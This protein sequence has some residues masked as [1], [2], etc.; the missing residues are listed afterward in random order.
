MVENGYRCIAF[1]TLGY[2]ESSSPVDLASY[3]IKSVCSQ[4]F[5]VLKQCNVTSTIVVG[6]DWGGLIAY[7]LAEWFPEL[8]QRMIVGCTPYAAP[9]REFVP[10][11]EVVKRYPS[12]NYQLY[13]V[14]EQCEKDLTSR[15]AIKGFLN[16]IH[17]KSQDYFSFQWNLE[18]FIAS[19]ARPRS[20]LLSEE[21]LEFYTDQFVKSGMSG[22]LNYYKTR[23]LNYEE[24]LQLNTEPLF[25]IPTLFISADRDPA[26]RPS[27]A[28]G[29]P[30][31]F[32]NLTVKS[33][34]SGHF[35]FEEVP[36]CAQLIISWLQPS[37]L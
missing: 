30:K 18:S 17:R 25:T 26:L 9:Q 27:M 22:P 34:H 7:R 23:R 29:M 4:I 33:V 3:T 19:A 37:K 8:V 28:K 6:H 32:K 1:D 2:G 35:V 11:P 15:P 20:D 10:L 14:S 13:L 31:Y 36:A 16:A 12:F 21:D 5:T 24:E